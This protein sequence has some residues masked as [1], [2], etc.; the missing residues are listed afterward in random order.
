MVKEIQM[1][2]ASGATAKNSTRLNDL[3]FS[4]VDQEG[5]LEARDFNSQVKTVEPNYKHCDFAC[6]GP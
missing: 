3:Q 1:L 4:V 2:Q 6:I 5:D